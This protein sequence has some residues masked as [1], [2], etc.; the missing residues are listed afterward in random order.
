[1]NTDETNVANVELTK[2]INDSNVTRTET[3]LIFGEANTTG[4]L[5]TKPTEETNVTKVEATAAIFGETNYTVNGT[6]KPTEDTK[7][8][9]AVTRITGEEMNI[10]EIRSN[11]PTETTNDF[12]PV[13]TTDIE[14]NRTEVMAHIGN[15]TAKDMT[16]IMGEGA[17]IS[18]DRERVKQ[19][20]IN[21]INVTEAETNHTGSLANQTIAETNVTGNITSAETLIT[22]ATTNAATTNAVDVDAKRNITT[23]ETN[24][25]KAIGKSIADKDIMDAVLNSIT[26]R[27]NVSNNIADVEMEETNNTQ[28]VTNLT[29]K[30]THVPKTI[31]IFE[32]RETNLTGVSHSN[33]SEN[34]TNINEA[35]TTEETNTSGNINNFDVRSVTIQTDIDDS[36]DYNNQTLRP[37]SGEIRKVPGE[38]P[39]ETSNVS[40]PFSATRTSKLETT[41]GNLMHIS[42]TE[43]SVNLT[44]VIAEQVVT[45]DNATDT[46]SETNATAPRLPVVVDKVTVVTNQSQNA[47]TQPVITETDNVT[48]HAILDNTSSS[49]IFRVI[50]IA[51]MPATSQSKTFKENLHRKKMTSST[52]Q[53]QTHS[54]K[55]VEMTTQTQLISSTSKS[56]IIPVYTSAS[57]TTEKTTTDSAIK[58]RPGKRCFRIIDTQGKICMDKPFQTNGVFI[59]A[60]NDRFFIWVF[61]VCQSTQLGVSHLQRVNMLVLIAYA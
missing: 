42:G 18:T 10:T 11:I 32:M 54:Q 27:A 38:E 53:T 17:K 1:M 28:A 33:K 51:S 2:N 48:R 24:T 30:R 14:T 58:V 22:D 5:T 3:K 37:V 45:R 46:K 60:T 39:T 25:T 12:K 43:K 29:A 41:T 44:A 40:E 4:N 21:E 47:S 16:N 31:K 34:E 26:E 8:A 7:V 49:P 13:N 36:S 35:V 19:A 56:D 15:I 61:F 55:T 23:S 50:T 52:E 57:S 6:I 20:M 59:K 9:E